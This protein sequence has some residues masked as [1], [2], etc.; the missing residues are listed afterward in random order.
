MR[1]LLVVGILVAGNMAFAGVDQKASTFVLCK[2]NKTVRTIRVTPENQNCKVTYSKAGVDEV[3][4]SNRSVAACKSFVANI[5]QNLESS[6]WNCREVSAAT[7][8]TSSEVI[9]R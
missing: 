1:A 7:V 4:G 2:N 6:K 3:V 8:T 9:A 5:K